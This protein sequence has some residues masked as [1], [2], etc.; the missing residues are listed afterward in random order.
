MEEEYTFPFFQ[1]DGFNCPFCGVFAHQDWY[2]VSLENA[3]I[4]KENDFSNDLSL[5]YC[6]KCRNYSIWIKDKIVALIEECECFSG[7]YPLGDSDWD[8]HLSMTLVVNG[9]IDD[10]DDWREYENAMKKC[11]NYLFLPPIKTDTKIVLP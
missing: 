1:G 3:N 6:D 7:K 4:N 9:V 10:V 8:Y 5:S 2:E 11:L